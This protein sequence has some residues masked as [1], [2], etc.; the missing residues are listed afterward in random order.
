MIF[1]DIYFAAGCG[2]RC[3]KGS[4]ASVRIITECRAEYSTGGGKRREEYGY[5]KTRNDRAEKDTI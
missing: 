3:S 5:Y 1:I 4:A 2:I